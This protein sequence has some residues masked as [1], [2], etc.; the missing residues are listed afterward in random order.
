[1]H[2]IYPSQGGPASHQASRAPHLRSNGRV[3]DAHPESVP[4]MAFEKYLEDPARKILNSFE[5]RKILN[6]S[7]ARKILN[8]S[9]VLFI[10]LEGCYLGCKRGYLQLYFQIKISWKK[11]FDY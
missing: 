1:M 8:Y 3:R 10:R 2:S 9:E 7:E 4:P 11:F 5:T 6:Y